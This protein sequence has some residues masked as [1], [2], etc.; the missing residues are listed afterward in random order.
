MS[1]Y[2]CPRPLFYFYRMTSVLLQLH[3]SLIII[4]RHAS[5]IEVGQGLRQGFRTVNPLPYFT[6]NSRGVALTKLIASGIS[7]VFRFAFYV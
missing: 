3:I 6:A 5:S 7:R 2:L 1:E 4:S